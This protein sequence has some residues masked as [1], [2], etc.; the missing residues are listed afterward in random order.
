MKILSHSQI[1]ERL[2][3][4]AVPAEGF[5]ARPC[6][7]LKVVNLFADHARLHRP[8]LIVPAIP[9]AKLPKRAYLPIIS[10]NSMS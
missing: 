9:L 4:L 8:A 10:Y 2:A 5:W 1:V 6:R 3:E 7:R